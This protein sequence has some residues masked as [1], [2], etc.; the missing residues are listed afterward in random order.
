FIQ[1]SHFEPWGVV[2][3]E[4]AAAKLPILCSTKVGSSSAFLRDMENGK[5]FDASGSKEIEE[6]LGFL[7]A[8]SDKELHAM[9]EISLKL[10][11]KITPYSWSATLTAFNLA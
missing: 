10:A 5:L 2:A 4:M 11:K 6:A 9:G 3:H 7:M 1:P 8:K